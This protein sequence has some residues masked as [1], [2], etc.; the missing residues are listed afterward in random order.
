MGKVENRS[1]GS[2]LHYVERMV[3]LQNPI[4]SAEPWRFFN[5]EEP[6]IFHKVFPEVL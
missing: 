4:G 3:L 6:R 5:K 2:L 1:K